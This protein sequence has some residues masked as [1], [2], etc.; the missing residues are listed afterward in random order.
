MAIIRSRFNRNSTTYPR[1]RT[2]LHWCR[3]REEII[4]FAGDPLPILLLARHSKSSTGRIR[5]FASRRRMTREMA[6]LI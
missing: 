4:A 2:Y 5:K 3:R 6:R 1:F